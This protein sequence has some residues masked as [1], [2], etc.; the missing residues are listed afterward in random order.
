MDHRY[1]APQYSVERSLG[2]V[3]SR[4]HLDSA[5]WTSGDERRV[6]AESGVPLNLRGDQEAVVS[7]GRWH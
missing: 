5:H 4:A 6:V 3:H 2:E 7:D 1:A